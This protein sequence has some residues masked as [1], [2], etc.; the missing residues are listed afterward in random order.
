MDFNQFSESL[1]NVIMKALQLATTSHHT[2]ITTVHMLEEMF[3][4][5]TIDGLYKRVGLDKNRCI[6]ICE[7]HFK[8]IGVVDYT[9][10]PVFNKK[11]TESLAQALNWSMENGETYMTEANAF[12]H[13]LF[14]NSSV[15]KHIL[16]EF[17]LKMDDVINAEL[18]RRG[19]KKMTEATSEQNLDALE[20]YGH[21]LVQD[22]IDGK[23]DPVIGRDEE[24]RRVIEILSR[25]TKNNPVLIGEPGVGK[26][27]VVEGLAWRIM[28]KD[29][30]LNLQDKK[31]IELDMGALI[32]GAKYR[33][34]FEERLKAVLEE[35]KAA[36][37]NIILFIVI[38]QILILLNK[39]LIKI[40]NS[41]K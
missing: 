11:V 39:R 6:E 20:K 17:P 3:K 22:V 27:A 25:K 29:V 5:D 12:I 32:A 36:D 16:N 18:E 24:I 7:E 40:P 34:E 1:Q 23:I 13:L 37:G 8:N 33:G 41:S 10:S 9:P 21:D 19:G 14:N 2:E 28:K 15:S 38:Y 4:D 35:I 30:P 31:I 26:T